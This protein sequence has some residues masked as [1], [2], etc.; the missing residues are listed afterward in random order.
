MLQ[1]LFSSADAIVDENA[2]PYE[3]DYE[4]YDEV[5]EG[6]SPFVNPYDPSHQT[7]YL[8]AGNLAG[9]LA[10]HRAS[11]EAADARRIQPT[12]NLQSQG[13]IELNLSQTLPITPKPLPRLFPQGNIKLDRFSDGYNFNFVSNKK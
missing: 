12:K 10:G 9:H 3:Y 2:E 13:L 4:Y 7:Q 8:L 1:Y 5:P 6:T 11:A